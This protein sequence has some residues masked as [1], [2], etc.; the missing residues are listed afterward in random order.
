MSVFL[1]EQATIWTTDETHAYSYREKGRN[2]ERKKRE[3]L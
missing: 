1:Y 3:T 2:G